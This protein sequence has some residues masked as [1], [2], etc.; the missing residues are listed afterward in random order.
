M[1]KR[2]KEDI[3]ER[4]FRLGARLFAMYPGLARR[5]QGHA[6]LARQLLKAGTGVA[7]QLEEA[8][9]PSSRRDMK[10]K[11]AIGLREAREGHLWARLLATDP[12]C[13]TDMAPIVAE[14]GEF[15]AMLTAAVKR[16]RRPPEDRPIDPP[17]DDSTA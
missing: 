7:A 15:V 11:Y 13:T 8:V 17:A 1:A 14:L 4:A 5:G 2:Y 16:L 6:V 12:N 9:A 3:R 10:E